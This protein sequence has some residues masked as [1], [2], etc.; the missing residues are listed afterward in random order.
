MADKTPL[1]YAVEGLK[2]Q[3]TTLEELDIMTMDPE[4]LRSLLP[5]EYDNYLEV[6]ECANNDITSVIDRA[7]GRA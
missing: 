2:E 3:L 6:L 7:C 5:S 1:Q 4:G